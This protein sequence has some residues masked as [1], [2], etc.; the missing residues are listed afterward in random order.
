MFLDTEENLWTD[1]GNH[2]RVLTEDLLCSMSLHKRKISSFWVGWIPLSRLWPQA[3]V[4][5][6]IATWPPEVYLPLDFSLSGFPGL[7]LSLR[8]LSPCPFLPSSPIT[9]TP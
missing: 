3:K 7:L 6:G 5:L 2:S 9:S 1:Y 4:G 8:L